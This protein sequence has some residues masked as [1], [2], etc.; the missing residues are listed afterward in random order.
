[1]STQT[2]DRRTTDLTTLI[3]STG[4][5]IYREKCYTETVKETEIPGE[6]T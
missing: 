6:G 1:M 3:L 5:V 4:D 2:V